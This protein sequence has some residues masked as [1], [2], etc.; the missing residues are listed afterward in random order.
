M[1]TT[2]VFTAIGITGVL[3]YLPVERGRGVIINRD[4]SSTKRQNYWFSRAAVFFSKCSLCKGSSKTR[5]DFKSSEWI[6]YCLV[7][8]LQIQAYPNFDVMIKTMIGSTLPPHWNPQ[9]GIR[10]SDWCFSRGIKKLDFPFGSVGEMTTGG[11]HSLSCDGEEVCY[12][13]YAELTGDL[14]GSKAVVKRMKTWSLETLLSFH[15]V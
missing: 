15:V 9:T 5:S 8:I 14:D 4:S 2:M 12:E 10:P 11:A 1:S 13:V 7:R 6:F 3:A